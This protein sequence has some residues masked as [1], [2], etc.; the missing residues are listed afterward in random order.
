MGCSFLLVKILMRNDFLCLAE[1]DLISSL[2][3]EDFSV[4]S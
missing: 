2:A 4:E 1:K 3:L